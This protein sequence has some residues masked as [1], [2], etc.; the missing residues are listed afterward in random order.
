MLRGDC[1][2][3]NSWNLASQ[4]M[5]LLIELLPVGILCK[6]TASGFTGKSSRQGIIS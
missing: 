3:E 1:L 2:L 4:T 5:Q 6:G